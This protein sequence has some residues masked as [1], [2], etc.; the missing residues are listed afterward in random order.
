MAVRR[1]LYDGTKDEDHP[2]YDEGNWIEI[3]PGRWV[4]PAAGAGPGGPP[5]AAGAGAGMPPNPAAGAG[6][7]GGGG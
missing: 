1:T 3:A 2:D 4:P 5:A 6:A 7:G